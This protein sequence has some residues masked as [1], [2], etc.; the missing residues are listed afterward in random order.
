[1]APP[2]NLT[3]ETPPPMNTDTFEIHKTLERWADIIDTEDPIT[4]R[5]ALNQITGWLY[6]SWAMLSNCQDTL[7]FVD[8]IFEIYLWTSHL[9]KHYDEYFPTQEDHL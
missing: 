5:D 1:M 6:G 7:K 4:H 3:K 9:S 8:E 2:K